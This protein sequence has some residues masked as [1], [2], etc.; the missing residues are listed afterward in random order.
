MKTYK[1]F[2]ALFVCFIVA[3]NAISMKTDAD[4]LEGFHRNCK[5]QQEDGFVQE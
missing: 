1:I 2:I 5:L 4:E 3:Q